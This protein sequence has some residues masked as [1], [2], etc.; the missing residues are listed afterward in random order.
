MVVAVDDSWDF[1]TK[2][3]QRNEEVCVKHKSL[4][5]EIQLRMRNHDQ[6]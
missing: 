6:L 5:R 4:V 1:M 2:A 3:I